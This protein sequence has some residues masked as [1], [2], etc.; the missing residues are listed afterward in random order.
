AHSPRRVSADYGVGGHRAADYRTAGDHRA[1]ADFGVDHGASGDP[2]VVADADRR[3]AHRPELRRLSVMAAGDQQ[4][5][6]GDGDVVADNDAGT[7]IE[8]TVP[9]HHAVLADTDAVDAEH[10]GLAPDGGALADLGPAQ[11]QPGET[12]GV[13]G[14]L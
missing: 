11:A 4:A 5:V 3:A 10:L 2:G 7:T 9:S 1:L 14:N 6:R 13:A 12:D 8:Q